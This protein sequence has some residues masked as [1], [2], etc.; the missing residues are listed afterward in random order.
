M[1]CNSPITSW[2]QAL[3]S[4]PVFL[5]WSPNWSPTKSSNQYSSHLKTIS[6]LS[7]II[8]KKKKLG[9]SRKNSYLNINK[10]FK[11]L[12]KIRDSQFN[13]DS[14]FSLFT[15]NP[16]NSYLANTKQPKLKKII[17]KLNQMSF[18]QKTP[19]FIFFLN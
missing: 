11:T 10:I 2:L 6:T 4:S 8:S 1:H 18:H 16:I 14:C 3:F 12:K 15:F 9:I 19:A 5:K 7:K 17:S 13:T